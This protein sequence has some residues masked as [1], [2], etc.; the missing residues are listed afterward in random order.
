MP[1]PLVEAQGSPPLVRRHT[2]EFLR[3]CQVRADL[4]SLPLQLHPLLL[5]RQVSDALFLG[6][7]RLSQLGLSQ[8]GK[9]LAAHPQMVVYLTDTPVFA[10]E[11]SRQDF[12]LFQQGRDFAVE[13]V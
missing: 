12:S 2:Q 10:A 3:R 13:N 4:G 11:P 6:H 7:P 8:P 1:V 9:F 5:R